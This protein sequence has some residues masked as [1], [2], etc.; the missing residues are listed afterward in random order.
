MVVHVDPWSTDFLKT[1]L[2]SKVSIK[3]VSFAVSAKSS[4]PDE[5]LDASDQLAPL[6]VE[7]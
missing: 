1:P 5:G 3:S 6:L 4:L 2:V 7:I